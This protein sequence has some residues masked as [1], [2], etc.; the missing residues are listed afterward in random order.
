M[1][2]KYIY[3]GVV[4]VV[5]ILGFVFWNQGRGGEKLLDTENKEVGKSAQTTTPPKTSNNNTNTQTG[6]PKQPVATI[7]TA[8]QLSGAIFRL[9]SYNGVPVDSDNKYTIS[10]D[11][12]QLTAKF[13]NTVSGMYVADSGSI[14][15][16]NLVG[17]KMYCGE[18]QNLMEIETSF[19][20]MLNFGAKI[21]YTDSILILSDAKT[22]MMFT[23]FIN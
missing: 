14:K 17:T 1:N 11:K 16:D 13:C 7:P 18:P 3:A 5:V 2:K 21:S 6:T 15:A 9:S 12:E 10:F 19:T 23:G 22:I 8:T 4:V 20:S